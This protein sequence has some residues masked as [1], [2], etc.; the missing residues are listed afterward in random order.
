M[1]QHHRRTD[2]SEQE[3]LEELV[4]SLQRQLDVAK[5]EAQGATRLG[6]RIHSQASDVASQLTSMGQARDRALRD[7]RL[8]RAAFAEIIVDITEGRDL[9]AS[10]NRLV[11]SLVAQGVIVSADIQRTLDSRPRPDVRPPSP[12]VVLVS[13]VPSSRHRVEIPRTER[14]Y[15]TD[16]AHALNAAGAA[17][18]PAAIA[19]GALTDRNAWSVAWD[20]AAGRWVVAGYEEPAEPDPPRSAPAAVPA[21]PENPTQEPMSHTEICDLADA[22]A[23]TSSGS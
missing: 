11:T 6:L 9:L 23:A 1:S 2:V 22:V 14:E 3:H 16:I 12:D 21:A 18:M 20:V 4:R 15:W 10:A 17:G 5:G 8:V 13:P 7:L 19:N